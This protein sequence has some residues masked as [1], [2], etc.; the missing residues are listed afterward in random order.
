MKKLAGLLALLFVL[1]AG[2]SEASCITLRWAAFPE[3]DYCSIVTRYDI[4]YS[5]NPITEN[6]WESANLARLAAPPVQIGDY[7]ETIIGGLTPGQK[8]HFALK[9]AHRYSNWSELSNNILIVAPEDPCSGT[10][11]NVDCDPDDLVDLA[12]L[13]YLVFHVFGSIPLCCEREANLDADQNGL[14]DL[15]DLGIMVSFLFFP[16]GSQPLPVCW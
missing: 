16:P 7:E 9:V 6:N 2:N 8:Y 4:R 5:T 12:D 15:S 11:G 14:I 10:V 1:Q 3:E 13:T